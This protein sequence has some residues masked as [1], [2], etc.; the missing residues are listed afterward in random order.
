MASSYQDIEQDQLATALRMG[1]A[2][3]GVPEMDIEE[4][5][6]LIDL[7]PEDVR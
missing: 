4:E 1:N 3:S 5:E 7:H 6:P 2:L